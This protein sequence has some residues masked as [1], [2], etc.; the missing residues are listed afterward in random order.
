[1][2]QKASK[3]QLLSSCSLALKSSLAHVNELSGPCQFR[4]RQDRCLL[5]RQDRCLL[6]RQDRCLLLRQD[7]F[8]LLRQDRCLSSSHLSCLNSRHLSCLNMYQQGPESSLTFASELFNARWH[9]ERSCFW[10]LPAAFFWRFL[11]ILNVFVC[12]MLLKN[13]CKNQH[14]YGRKISENGPKMVPKPLQNRSQRGSGG[15]LGATLETRCFQDVIFDD[16]GSILGPPLGPFW[17]HFGHHFFDVSLGWLF[18]G[19]GLHLG[20][21]NTSKMKPNR[22]S[23]SK[24]EFY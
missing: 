21:Q 5:L 12:D 19:F 1:M 16:F 4:L 17:G 2:Q 14:K 23:K 20:S 22:G 13:T 11:V 6:L 15:L 18:D 3:K 10:K 9:E 7:R 24:A 8:L